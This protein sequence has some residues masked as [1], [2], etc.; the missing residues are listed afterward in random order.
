VGWDPPIAV[1]VNIAVHSSS[2]AI[3]AATAVIADICNL[4]QTTAK[5]GRGRHSNLAL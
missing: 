2:S 3:I 5:Q 1:I 4:G